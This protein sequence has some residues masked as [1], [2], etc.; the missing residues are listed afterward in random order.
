[1]LQ[2]RRAGL[3]AFLACCTAAAVPR[4]AEPGPLSFL[5]G[6]W[7]GSGSGEPGQGLGSFSFQPDLQD[8]VLVRRAHSEYPATSSRPATVHEDLLIVYDGSAKAIYFDNEGHVIHYS[9]TTDPSAKTATFL[10]ADPAPPGFRLTYTEIAPGQLRVVFDISPS[11]RP[12]DFKTY[13]S[14]VVTRRKSG[15]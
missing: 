1:M 12:A 14:G 2:K 15:R 9:I 10:S 13:V 6:E 11:G 4:A 3:I 8:R 5:V 7:S